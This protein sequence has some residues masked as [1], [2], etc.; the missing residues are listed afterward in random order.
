[1]RRLLGLLA[2]LLVGCGVKFG[3]TMAYEHSMPA[4]QI[5]AAGQ[6][7]SAA[8]GAVRRQPDDDEKRAR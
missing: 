7:A 6:A 3:L 8:A 2:F 1:M 5:T 4:D